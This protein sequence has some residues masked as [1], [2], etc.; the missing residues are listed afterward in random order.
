MQWLLAII[1]A[2]LALSVLF[3]PRL[4]VADP[5]RLSTGMREP[6]TNADGT[7]FTDLVIK[8]AF[9][10]LDIPVEVVVNFAA[11]RALALADEGVDDGL[12]ARIAGLEKDY[13]NL[14][15]VPE[16][17]F[18]NDFV[19]ASLSSPSPH[20]DPAPGWDGLSPYSVAYILG[21]QVFDNNLKPV[22]EVTHAKDS[23]QLLGL[24][25]AGRAEV[26][27]HERWQALWHARQQGIIIHIHEPPLARVPMYAYLHK[28]HAGLIDRLSRELTAMKA[29]G[30]Y[31][32]L[33]ERAFGGL[34][35]RVVLFR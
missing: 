19:A 24:L 20:P 27:L 7:G 12:T 9:R 5:L 23:A 4:G 18:D 30:T 14:L 26:I 22:R 17:I 15:R 21:W 25:K 3:A 35:V 6:W 34:G 28:R 11:A 32:M 13:P 10:R 16:K 31:Q 8:E 1:R 29:D 33:A 2:G